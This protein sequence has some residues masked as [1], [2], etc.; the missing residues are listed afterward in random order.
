MQN[1]TF[2]FEP[3]PTDG[4][5]YEMVVPDF[6][7]AIM[8]ILVVLFGLYLIYRYFDKRQALTKADVKPDIERDISCT[9]Y[10]IGTYMGLQMFLIIVA[11]MIF[12]WGMAFALEDFGLAIGVMMGAFGL[13]LSGRFYFLTQAR[14]KSKEQVN[15][16]GILRLKSGKPIKYVF[17]NIKFLAEAILSKEEKATIVKES[18]GV[19]L[20]DLGK[21]FAYPVEV[22][23]RHVVWLISSTP[24]RE[25]DT[26]MVDDIDAWGEYMV[27]VYSPELREI[28]TIHRVVEDEADAEFVRDEWIPVLLVVWDSVRSK[29]MVGVIPTVDVTTSD[30][31]IGLTKAIGA[32]N[33]ITAGELNTTTSAL[34]QSQNDDKDFDDLT[35]SIG[36]KKALEFRRSEDALTR[37]SIDTSWMNVNLLSLVLLLVGL[38]VGYFLGGG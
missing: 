5:P 6:A 31:L 33:T 15:M 25:W 4:I 1:E 34:L 7:T 8:L 24:Y 26:L 35:K 9:D 29:E 17:R 32:E 13:M 18:V 30:A 27:P 2:A 14:E 22:N 10:P 3:N 20:K 37:F 38:G 12:T 23:N 21:V 16:E 19:T 11:F 36:R 28:A